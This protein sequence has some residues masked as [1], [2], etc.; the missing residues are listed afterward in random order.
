MKL[1]HSEYMLANVLHIQSLTNQNK[2][3]KNNNKKTHAD[4]K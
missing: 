4:Q 3:T 2:H 1:N